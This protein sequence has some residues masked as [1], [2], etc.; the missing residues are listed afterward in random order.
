MNKLFFFGYAKGKPKKERFIMKRFSAIIAV[1]LLI[2]CVFAGCGG[3]EDGKV[4]DTTNNNVPVLTTDNM[5]DGM[6]DSF[7]DG[8]VSDT[9]NNSVTL[10][11]DSSSTTM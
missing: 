2:A 11:T 10:V 5:T 3:T 4:T 8:S 6:S 7:E 1:M 9:T